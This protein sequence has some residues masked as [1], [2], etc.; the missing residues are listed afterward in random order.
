MG[1]AVNS[2]AAAKNNSGRRNVGRDMKTSGRE[3]LEL[4]IRS[5]VVL[6]S[7]ELHVKFSDLLHEAIRSSEIP[8]R[9]EPGAE[10]ALTE[11]IIELLKAWVAIHEPDDA[12]GDYEYGQKALV[13]R[14]LE[15]LEDEEEI[16]LE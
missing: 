15:E 14:M 1:A 5:R 2:K 9:F 11:P 3:G 16:P 10:E 7:R 12:S 4:I 8:L 6:C 13:A